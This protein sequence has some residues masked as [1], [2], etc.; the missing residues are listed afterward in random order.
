VPVDRFGLEP[1]ALGRALDGGA[2]A[3][4]AVPRAQNPT[5]AAFD[6]D[7]A[8]DLNAVFR[9]HP[10]VLVIEDDHAGPVA[11]AP[12]LT[13]TAGLTHWAVV[14][15]YAKSLAPDLRVAALAGDPVTVARIQGRQ[16]VGTGWVSHILQAAAA[17]L[18]SRRST[19]TQLRTA[20]R[21]YHER[22][23]ALIEA[24]G[25]HGISAVG[26]TGLNIWVPVPEEQSVVRGLLDAGWAVA[27]GEPF[28]RHSGPAVRI[29]T[30]GLD[31]TEAPLL[32][33][34]VAGA[35]RPS[36]RRTG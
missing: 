1:L 2:R 11:G 20:S 4:I 34:A 8:R 9:L 22:S 19:H 28:R 29:T 30:A 3:V 32:A 36:H 10:T 15:S 31:S 12:A 13:S 24:L 14:R 17:H 16:S 23:R 5:G 21:R 33:A 6:A 35:L 26:G 25:A 18:L 7:R 27:A